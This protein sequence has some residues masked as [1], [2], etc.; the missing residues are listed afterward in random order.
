LTGK[1]VFRIKRGARGDI[2][3]YKGAVGECGIT[4]SKQLPR[5]WYNSLATP[6]HTQ[7]FKPLDANSSVFCRDGTII[8]I[9][10]DAL[11]IVGA[12]DPDIDSKCQTW[13]HVTSTL[14]HMETSSRLVPAEPGNQADPAFRRSHQSASGWSFH[15]R[16]AWCPSRLA[17]AVSVISR[18]SSNPTQAHT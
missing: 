13:V 7:G 4:V 1:W 15:V 5:V 8:P 6:L 16:H 2:I 10:V 18:S 3:C 12:S 9:Y 11:L 17:Y 14:S